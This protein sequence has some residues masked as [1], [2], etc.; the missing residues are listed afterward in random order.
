LRRLRET[1][2]S[3]F[4]EAYTKLILDFVNET[5]RE[6]EDS[7]NW[8]MLRSI[9]TV[10]TSSGTA[11]YSIVGAGQRYRF[12]PRDDGNV[13][14]YDS[15]NQ[16]RLFLKEGDWVNRQ[17]YL[18]TITPS[19]PTDFAV[20]GQDVNLDPT[21]KLYPTPN[22]IYSLKFG[23]VI[24]QAELTAI[25]DVLTLPWYPIVIGSWA[26]AI[27]ERGEDGGQ[28]TIEQ[29]QMYQTALGDAIQQDVART[30]ETTWQQI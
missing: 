13:F 5:K 1:E 27:S 9:K 16:L 20:V 30:G 6:V 28:N 2:I 24:P 12:L 18:Q 3:D 25:T 21:I 23:L 15:T 7:W 10:T 19:F 8:A 11:D 4:N 29:W 22:G 14:A 17:Q 26:K